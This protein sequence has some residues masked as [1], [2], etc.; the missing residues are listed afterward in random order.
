MKSPDI[1]L[2]GRDAQ[3]QQPTLEKVIYLK[4]VVLIN[5]VNSNG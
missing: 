3:L 2:S 1:T 5:M 4:G